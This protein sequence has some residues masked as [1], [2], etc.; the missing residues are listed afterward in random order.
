MLVRSV[1]GQNHECSTKIIQTTVHLPL[2]DLIVIGGGIGSCRYRGRCSRSWSQRWLIRKPWFLLLLLHL[3]VPKLIHGGL[4][5]LSITSFV[6][7]R[8]ALAE[9]RNIVKK[10]TSCCST[11]AFPFTLI[12][13]FYAQLGWS[14]WLFPYDNLGKHFP[15]FRR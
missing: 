11:N 12:D 14:L 6:W 4:R 8:K 15:R 13:H 3:Q 2:L 5:Y 1:R 10:S 7:F 9:R